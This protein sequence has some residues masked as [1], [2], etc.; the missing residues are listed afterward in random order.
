LNPHRLIFKVTLR[1]LL[2]VLADRPGTPARFLVLGSAS[3]DLLRQSSESLAGRIDHYELGGLDIEEVG[4]PQ[5]DLLWLRGEFPRSF[6][7]ESDPA[8]FEWRAAFI[9][10]FVERDLPQLGVTIPSETLHR[11]WSMLAHYHAQLWN[12]AELARAFGVSATAV[13]RYLDVLSSALVIRQFASLVREP[14]QE[15]GA[16]R[17]GGLSLPFDFYRN[18]PE[19]DR[20]H[21]RTFRRWKVSCWDFSIRRRSRCRKS[22]S[23]YR[24]HFADECNDRRSREA[25]SRGLKLDPSATQLRFFETIS[26]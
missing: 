24:L 9:R 1:S 17:L 19:G 8:S 4:M 3:P 14:E 21:G 11:F 26:D 16:G 2:R 22:P 6:L 7:A 10:T 12:G 13:R 23:L 18:E 15:A 20:K 25:V 5:R